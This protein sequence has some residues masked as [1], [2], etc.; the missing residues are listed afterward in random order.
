MRLYLEQWRRHRGLSRSEFARL[1]GVHRV[2]VWRWEKGQRVPSL[3]RFLR[4]CRV[5]DVPPEELVDRMPRLEE[6]PG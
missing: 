6:W 5:L 4:M 3:P 2:E 1:L